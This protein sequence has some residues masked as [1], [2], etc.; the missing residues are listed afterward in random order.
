MSQMLNDLLLPIRDTSTA[1]GIPKSRDIWESQKETLQEV[2]VQSLMLR[3]EL[4]LNLD[5]YDF[6]WPKP[7]TPFSKVMMT[8]DNADSSIG[9]FNQVT[10]AITLFPGILAGD[11]K[12]MDRQR[13]SDA[14][15]YEGCRVVVKALV[16]TH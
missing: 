10:V 13:N 9:S 14:D 12:F 8:S 1:D 2:F 5:R 4:R 3:A 11:P 16:M 15:S 6:F 7:K